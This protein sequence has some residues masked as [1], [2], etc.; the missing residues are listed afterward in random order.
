MLEEVRRIH[1]LGIGGIGVSAVARILHGRGFEVSG[2]DVRESS[3]TE[4]L[5]AEGVTV[6][7]GHKPE[8][9]DC[10]LYTSPSPRD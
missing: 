7:I 5:R 1:M 8:N 9:I 2:S 6:V 3:L 4:A 10:L